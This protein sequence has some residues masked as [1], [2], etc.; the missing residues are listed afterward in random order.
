M[1]DVAEILPRHMYL[2]RDDNDDIIA[3][4]IEDFA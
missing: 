4:L 3:A 1:I 2:I